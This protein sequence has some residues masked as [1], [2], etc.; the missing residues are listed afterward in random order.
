[1]IN[2][3]TSISLSLPLSRYACDIEKLTLEKI[4]DEKDDTEAGFS[5]P[6]LNPNSNNRSQLLS[7]E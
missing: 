7:E 5:N 2:G 4:D 1:M 3:C 6:N